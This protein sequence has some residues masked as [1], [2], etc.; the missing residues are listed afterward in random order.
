VE[1]EEEEEEEEE[2]S[3]LDLLHAPARVDAI[4]NAYAAGVAEY[5]PLGAAGRRVLDGFLVPVLLGYFDPGVGQTAATNH[6]QPI[7]AWL[8]DLREAG[9]DVGV[10][11]SVVFEYWWAD[12]VLVDA[13]S[14]RCGG[15]DG[16]GSGAGKQDAA[17]AAARL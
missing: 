5:K 11:T 15:S 12:C 16:G 2:R 17:G 14:S 8:E 9:F 1:E 13:R 6:E 3:H 10:E 4:L 7:A